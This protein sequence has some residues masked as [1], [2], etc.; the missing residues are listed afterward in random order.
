MASGKPVVAVD[1]GGFRETVTPQ[2]GLLVQPSQDR[3]IDAIKSISG[4]PESYYGACIERARD[5]DLNIF[6]KNITSAVN[7]AYSDY[8]KS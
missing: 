1:E 4:N 8:K 7:E 5:F 3:I 6:K 2:T